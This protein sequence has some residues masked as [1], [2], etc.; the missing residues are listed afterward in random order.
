MKPRQMWEE[1]RNHPLLLS[2]IYLVSFVG[3]IV[4]SLLFASPAH[5]QTTVGLHL[6]TQ[7][8]E[9]STQDLQTL[10]PGV[11]LRTES[12]F[13]AG[14]FR[15]SYSRSS[16]YAGWTWQTDDGRFALTAGAITGYSAAKVMPLV[17]PSV[18]FELAP[19]TY[20]RTAYV[21]KP[22]KHGHSSGLHLSIE[23]AVAP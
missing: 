6:A 12:G 23:W 17:T 9:H 14:S 19:G 20:L 3:T 10:T 4:F 15:N 16:V 21:P 7:H 18:R 8:L 13:T 2:I 22:L 11:Y 5:A 1:E